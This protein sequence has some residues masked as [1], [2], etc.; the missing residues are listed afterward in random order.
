M[1]FIVY[2]GVG[3]YLSRLSHWVGDPGD[4]GRNPVTAITFSCAAI[5]F[6][7]VYNL[8]HHQRSAPFIPCLYGVGG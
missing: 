6:P 7:I 8:Q 2:N 4:T 3:R 1:G 5:H